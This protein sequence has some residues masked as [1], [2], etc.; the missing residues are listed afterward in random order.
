MPYIRELIRE[1]YNEP[2]KALFNELIK[3]NYSTGELN[4]CLT[5]LIWSLFNHNQKYETANSLLGVLESV[6]LEFY[7]KQVVPYESKKEKENG[8]VVLNQGN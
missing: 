2:V 6:K 4:Y 5:L 8:D 7:R 3:N 1:K